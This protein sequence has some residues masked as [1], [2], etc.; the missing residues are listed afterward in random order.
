MMELVLV[1]VLALIFFGPGKLPG[2]GQALGK[3]LREFR[4]ATNEEPER[5]A[6]APGAVETD[7]PGQN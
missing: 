5:P 7:R 4:K 6:E 3:T 2:V 1:L